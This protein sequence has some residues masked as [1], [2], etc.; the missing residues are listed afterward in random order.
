LWAAQGSEVGDDHGDRGGRH[1]GHTLTTYLWL[2][3]ASSRSSCWSSS[4]TGTTATRTISGHRPLG[5][6]ILLADGLH[7]LAF[8][9]GLAIL[10]AAAV[11]AGA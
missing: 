2:A 8:S 9:I 6:L 1:A 3:V 7:S 10:L 4:S 11:V 5:Y